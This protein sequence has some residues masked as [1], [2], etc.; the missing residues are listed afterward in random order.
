MLIRNYQ[1]NDE[2][3]WI[4]CRLLAFVDT[5]YF[6]DVQRDKELEV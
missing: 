1:E 6:D 5:A 2:K 4:R 3:S